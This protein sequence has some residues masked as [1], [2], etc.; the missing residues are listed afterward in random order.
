M[1][2]WRELQKADYNVLE[3]NQLNLV[4][5]L[6][7]LA[8]Q[9]REYVEFLGVSGDEGD[10]AVVPHREKFYC[11][12]DDDATTGPCWLQQRAAAL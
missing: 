6:L 7:K 5:L 9:G 1:N 4:L 12:R 2:K 8:L 11:L 3:Q 10:L